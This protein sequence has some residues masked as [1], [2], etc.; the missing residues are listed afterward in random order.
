MHLIILNTIKTSVVAH[1]QISP[2]GGKRIDRQCITS[3]RALHQT[4]C[5]LMTFASTSE[6]ILRNVLVQNQIWLMC[7][8]QLKSHLEGKSILHLWQTH[9]LPSSGEYKCWQPLITFMYSKLKIFF[10]WI[11]QH[12]LVKT[13]RPIFDSKDHHITLETTCS[14]WTSWPTPSI[15]VHFIWSAAVSIV[16]VY[17]SRGL[18]VNAGVGNLFQKFL[19]VIFVIFVIVYMCAL[20]TC[21]HCA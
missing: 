15:T 3:H 11:W 18:N 7:A 13:N 12:T 4:Y 10:P 6:S 9:Y 8:P 21:T 19:F 5:S 17:L 14:A 20:C 16:T 1:S 2:G